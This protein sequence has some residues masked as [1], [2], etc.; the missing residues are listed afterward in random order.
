[1]SSL[2]DTLHEEI[3]RAAVCVGIETSVAA[4][5]ACSVE[6]GLRFREGGHNHYLSKKDRDAFNGSIIA[7]LLEGSCVK[8]ISE[9]YNI[10]RERVYQLK[11]ELEK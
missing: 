1:M 4:D 11:R 9:K 2:I 5:I 8:A 7:E 6:D 10:S 3:I